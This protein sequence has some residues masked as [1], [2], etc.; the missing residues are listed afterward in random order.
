MWTF[1]EAA[2]AGEADN[3]SSVSASACHIGGPI[4]GNHGELALV[5][6]IWDIPSHHFQSPIKRKD[7]SITIILAIVF[8]IGIIMFFEDA[9]YAFKVI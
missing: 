1:C 6:A 9:K 4:G 2:E 8:F 3:V 7:L 5:Y